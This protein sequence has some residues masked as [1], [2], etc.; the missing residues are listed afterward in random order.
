MPCIQRCQVNSGY[1]GGKITRTILTN[2]IIAEPGV[3]GMIS[4][5]RMPNSYKFLKLLF[6]QSLLFVLC[7]SAASAQ[8]TTAVF[9]RMMAIRAPCIIA[10]PSKKSIFI[11]IDLIMPWE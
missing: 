11:L 5:N 9:N 7:Y 4:I 6:T 1:F 2:E 8:D 3:P 10:I